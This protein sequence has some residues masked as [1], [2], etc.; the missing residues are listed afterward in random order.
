M[1]QP[2][3]KILI[4]R[5]LINIFISLYPGVGAAPLGFAAFPPEML[6]APATSNHELNEPIRCS[7]GRSD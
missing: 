1:H 4:Y 6:G 2:L 5:P 7:M 3:F